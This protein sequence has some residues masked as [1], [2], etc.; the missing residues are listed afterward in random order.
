M[1]H[2]SD[3]NTQGGET[4]NSAVPSP[5]LDALRRLQQRLNDG[6]LQVISKS[7][8]RLKRAHYLLG[9]LLLTDPDLYS[10]V[11]PFLEGHLSRLGPA[12]Q[13]IDNYTSI[14]ATLVE[15]RAM[16]R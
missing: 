10:Q 1:N 15:V 11:R 13:V 6:A 14:R 12:R 16:Q 7:E 2:K 4:E 5:E 8:K 9:E 3:S